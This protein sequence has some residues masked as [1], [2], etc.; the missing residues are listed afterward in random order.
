[1]LLLALLASTLWYSC[2]PVVEV[3]PEPSF[4]PGVNPPVPAES[5]QILTASTYGCVPQRTLARFYVR[6]RLFGPSDAAV[7]R[8]MRRRAG[9]LGAN[10]VAP[11]TPSMNDLPVLGWLDKVFG[12]DVEDDDRLRHTEEQAGRAIALRCGVIEGDPRTYP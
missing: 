10:A 4:E 8:V 3:R 11:T 5:V 9:E 2:Q 12:D 6:G 7:V 1:M